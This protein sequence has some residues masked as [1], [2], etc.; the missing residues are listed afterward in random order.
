M[1]GGERQDR[2]SIFFDEAEQGQARFHGAPTQTQA[3]TDTDRQT[4]T[5]TGVAAFVLFLIVSLGVLSQKF[6]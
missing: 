6:C 5:H 2:K 4:D 1:A 3:Q